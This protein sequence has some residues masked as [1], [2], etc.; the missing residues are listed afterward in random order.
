MVPLEMEDMD[1][2]EVFSF[3]S[4]VMSAVICCHVVH[5]FHEGVSLDFIRLLPSQG[6]EASEEDCVICLEPIEGLGYGNHTDPLIKDGV[7]TFPHQAVRLTCGHSFGHRCIYRWLCDNMS[8]PTCRSDVQEDSV[9]KA[10][11]T[12]IRLPDFRTYGIEVPW[13]HL[14][15]SC[16]TDSV[17][18]WVFSEVKEEGIGEEGGGE[19]LDREGEEPLSASASQTVQPWNILEVV[20]PKCKCDFLERL[21]RHRRNHLSV[22]ELIWQGRGIMQAMLVII[23]NTL[24]E[25]EHYM[26]SPVEELTRNKY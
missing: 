25:S 20:E 5:G 24:E 23:D 22:G 7:L 21:K 15:G 16:G 14:G 1:L 26:E 18:I 4:S 9:N 8:C 19:E 6:K 3:V 2:Q 13:T 17:S 10:V 12:L 11:P